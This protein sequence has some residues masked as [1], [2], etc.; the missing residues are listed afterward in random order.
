MKEDKYSVRL[1]FSHGNSIVLQLKGC[2][3]LTIKPGHDYFFEN[4]PMKFI[5]YLAQL[6]RLG[7]TYKITQEGSKVAILALG[8]FYQLGESVAKAI[9]EKTGTAPTLIN[10]RY[11]TGLDIEMLES[12]KANHTQIITLEDGILDGGFGEKIARFY[13]PTDLKVYNYGLK[14]EFIDRYKAEDI[15]KENHLTPEQILEDLGL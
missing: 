3:S 9:E 7:V 14:K 11:I 10:P 5:N 13:G 2:G 6:R 8:D 12:L 1:F 4:A 15:L